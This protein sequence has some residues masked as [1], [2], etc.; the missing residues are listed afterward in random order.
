MTLTLLRLLLVFLYFV[1]LL[2]LLQIPLD[3]FLLLYELLN[4]FQR[5]LYGLR[6]AV[7][8][9]FG[10]FYVCEQVA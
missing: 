3:R 6:Q 10:D 4:Y 7:H 2:V 1:L 5:L 8:I 9:F